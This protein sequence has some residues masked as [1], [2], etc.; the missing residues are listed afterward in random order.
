MNT[1]KTAAKPKWDEDEVSDSANNEVVPEKKKNKLK[2]VA[3]AAETK[4]DGKAKKIKKKSKKESDDSSDDENYGASLDKLK[5]IDPEF[6]KV[7]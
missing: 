6:Y 1:K 5:E 3:K 2:K 4:K 7:R